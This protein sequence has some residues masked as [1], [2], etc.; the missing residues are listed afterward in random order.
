MKKKLTEKRNRN[1]F[2]KALFL[3][4]AEE[5]A[6]EMK[7]PAREAYDVLMFEFQFLFETMDNGAFN[8]VRWP[9]VGMIAISEKG[10]VSAIKRKT[11]RGRAKILRNSQV[12]RNA[13]PNNIYW[14]QNK[15]FLIELDKEQEVFEKTLNDFDI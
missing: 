7:I 8:N 10:I 3:Q 5:L 14:E 13:N 6:K 15:D 9:C 11:F 1:K 4:I 2:D 12:V